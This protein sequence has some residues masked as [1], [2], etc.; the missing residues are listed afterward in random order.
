MDSLC[1]CVYLLKK[2]SLDLGR[3]LYYPK[4]NAFIAEKISVR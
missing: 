1:I 4:V 2:Y 3:W